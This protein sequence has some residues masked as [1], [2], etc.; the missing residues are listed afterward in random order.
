[1][2]SGAVIQCLS[3][4]CTLLSSSGISNNHFYVENILEELDS[5]GEWWFDRSNG[6]LYIMPNG[7]WNANSVISIPMLDTLVLINGSSMS[8]PATV[9]WA[10]LGLD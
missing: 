5:P 7:T 6:S 4:L 3:I 2:H 1:M 8:A 10:L 9:C